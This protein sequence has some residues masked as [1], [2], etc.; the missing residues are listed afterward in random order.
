MGADDPAGW[1]QARKLE[2]LKWSG[3]VVDQCRGVNQKLDELF[4]KAIDDAASRINE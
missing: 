2:Y 4:D 3:R 1:D